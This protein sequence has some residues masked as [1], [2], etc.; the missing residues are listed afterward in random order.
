M[1]GGRARPAFDVLS[2]VRQYAA[3]LGGAGNPRRGR[4]SSAGP[5]TRGGAGQTRAGAAATAG[6]DRG[7]R[8]GPGNPRQC[9]SPERYPPRAGRRHPIRS[10]PG[11]ER[12]ANPRQCRRS[13]RYRASRGRFGATDRPRSR[14]AG[15]GLRVVFPVRALTRKVRPASARKVRPASARSRARR[16]N[17]ARR[18]PEAGRH[19]PAPRSGATIRRH[20]PAPRRGS[21]TQMGARWPHPADGP[22]CQM[23]ARR[24]HRCDVMTPSREGAAS[25]GRSRRPR[26]SPGRSSPTAPDDQAPRAPQ[27]RVVPRAAAARSASEPRWTRWVSAPLPAR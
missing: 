7:R 13:A 27:R 14:S 4:Q 1:P 18:A 17:R 19:D 9:A 10:D 26:R 12:P 20:D 25:G 5:A 6:V 23:A 24:P 3:I 22:A 16:G 8:S 2:G 11:A 15:S 21:R